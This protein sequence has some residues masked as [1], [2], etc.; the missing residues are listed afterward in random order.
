MSVVEV[1]QGSP[2]ADAL[3]NAIQPKLVELGWSTGGLDDSALAEYIVL[4]LVNGKTQHEI[5]TEVAQDLLGLSAEESNN[6]VAFS[7]WLFEQIITLSGRNVVLAGTMAPEVENAAS[8]T[9]SGTVPAESPGVDE[10][11]GDI[12]NTGTTAQDESAMYVVGKHF[13]AKR[14]VA[15]VVCFV[16]RLDLSPC[17]YPETSVC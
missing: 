9:A 7:Q 3:Q 8:M 14:V 11:M 10:D 15:N 16:V 6:A 1:A 17:A 2:L 5:A 13:V 12:E 4:M